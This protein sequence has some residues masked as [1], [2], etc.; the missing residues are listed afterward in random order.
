MNINIASLRNKAGVLVTSMKGK[1]EVFQKHYEQL[2]RVS[3][4]SGFDFELKKVVER[5]VSMCSSLSEVYEDEALDR[6]VKVG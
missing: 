2:R 4:D 5:K 6:N 1:L 3:V